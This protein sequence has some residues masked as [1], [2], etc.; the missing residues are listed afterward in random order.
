[1]MQAL[2]VTYERLLASASPIRCLEVKDAAS[3]MEIGQKM[4]EA[5]CLVAAVRPPTV[6]TS[7]LRMTVMATHTAAQIEQLAA[8][9]AAISP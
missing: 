1:M 6:P 8:T 5:G 3:V 4:L 7:R 9:L 2:S